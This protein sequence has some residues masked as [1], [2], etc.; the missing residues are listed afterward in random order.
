MKVQL[1]PL[2]KNLK[3]RS[4]MLLFICPCAVFIFWKKNAYTHTVQW[5]FF[6]IGNF[7]FRD[8]FLKV[9]LK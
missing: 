2:H 3:L 9:L 7:H 8:A 1:V 4:V 5:A 6:Y